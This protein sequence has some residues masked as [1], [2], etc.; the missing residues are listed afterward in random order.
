MRRASSLRAAALA[1]AFAATTLI[2]GCGAADR[3]QGATEGETPSQPSFQYPFDANR[4]FADLEKQVAFGPRNPGSE[5]HDKCLKWLREEVGKSADRVITQSFQQNLGGRSYAFTNVFGIY[6]DGSA[7]KWVLLAAHW[8]SRPFAD[9]DTDEQK[10]RQPIPGAND[11][12]SGVAVLL[13]M[14]RMLHEKRPGLG[15]VVALLDG[16]DFGRSTSNMF[17]GS[18]E[19]AKR[20]KD[21]LSGV[22]SRFEYGILLDMV[23]AKDMRIPREGTSQDA[24][25]QVMD[26]IWANAKKAGLSQQFPD[27]PGEPIQDDHIPLIAAGIPTVDLICFNYAYWHTHEDTP[28]KCAP[29]SLK[30]VG[31]VVARTLYE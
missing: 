31:E 8:D 18:R 23:G 3:Q 26:R 12:A 11:G 10:A 2:T 5:G 14:G 30:A 29:A 7:K 15:V 4:A 25:P 19:F 13:E 17:L 6:G 20:W 28:D 21:L 9:Q 27:T 16:E 24:T 1:L 22:T